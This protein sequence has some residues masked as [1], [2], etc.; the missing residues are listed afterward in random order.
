MGKIGC[1][2]RWCTVNTFIYK[3]YIIQY[4]RER[5]REVYYCD[6]SCPKLKQQRETIIRTY[7]SVQFQFSFCVLEVHSS[8]FLLFRSLCIER[9][10]EVLK[11]SVL[12]LV[13]LQKSGSLSFIWCVV[14]LMLKYSC[15]F[16]FA[17]L[18]VANFSSSF[19]LLSDKV[20]RFNC[21]RADL[22]SLYFSCNTNLYSTQYT[23]LSIQ[24]TVYIMQYKVCSTQYT[25]YSLQYTL[26][27]KLYTV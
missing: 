21:I 8:L 12:A 6:R 18:V 10:L 14:F 3:V 17:M 11:R 19:S 27:S 5:E 20:S 13:V 15:N 22:Q 25:I 2:L 24:Y 23:V 26:Y 7:S 1:S 4:T 16:R 9:M